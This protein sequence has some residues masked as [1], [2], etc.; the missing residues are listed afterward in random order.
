MSFSKTS[1]PLIIADNQALTQAGFLHLVGNA[2][3]HCAADIHRLTALLQQMP[4]AGILLDYALFDLKSPEHLLIV[5]HRFPEATW[6]LVSDDYGSDLLRLLSGERR[7][8]FLPKDSAG[9]EVRRALDELAEGRR[10]VAESIRERLA[11]GTPHSGDSPLTATEQE[12]VR[13][14]ARGLSAREIAEQR[15]SSIHTIITHKKNIFRKLEVNT[16]YE[17]TRYALRAGL[18][19]P[20]EYFI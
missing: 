3:H 15:H 5:A 18:A 4:T 12:V 14:L 13:L 7:V 17:V 16:V 2:P 9:D 10:Y 11:T 8:G 6:L 20:V 1:H 19:D